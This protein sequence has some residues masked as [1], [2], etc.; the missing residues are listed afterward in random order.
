MKRRLS[1]LLIFMLLALQ[2]MAYDF[3]AVN[4]D[5]QTIYYNILSSNT[6][7]VAAGPAGAYIGV[8]NIPE[9]VTSG[10]VTYDVVGI[11]VSAFENCVELTTVTMPESIENIGNFAMKGCT[12]LTSVTIPNVTITFGTN[13]LENCTS[14]VTFDVPRYMTAIPVAFFKGC[15]SLQSI[16]TTNSLVSILWSAFEGCTGL[17]SD[18]FDIPTSVQAIS[19]NAFKNCTGLTNI[20]IPE[21]VTFI[22]NNTFDNCSSLVQVT[23]PSTLTEIEAYAFRDCSS[24]ALINFPEALTTIGVYAFKSCTSLMNVNMANTNVNL[25]NDYAFEDCTSLTNVTFSDV[26]THTGSYSFHNC[27]ELRSIAFP[28]SYTNVGAR[29]F[30]GCSMLSEV[31]L[32]ST[33][34]SIGSQA[35]KDCVHLLI[36]RCYAHVPPTIIN[37]NCFEGI[38]TEVMTIVVPCSVVDAYQALTPWNLYNIECD[39]DILIQTDVMPFD[40]GYILGD[41]YFTTDEEVRLVAIPRNH[42]VFVSWKEDD[43]VVSTDS[44]YTFTATHDRFLTAIFRH[45]DHLITAT[46]YPEGYGH[47]TGAGIYEYSSVARLMAYPH[48][49]YQFYYWTEN[50]SIVS[51]NT[52]YRFTV[53]YDRDLVAH[54]AP[55]TYNIT[56]TPSDPLAGT[57]SGD[58]TYTYNDT[59]TVEATVNDHY[60]WIG[61]KEFGSVVSTDTTYIFQADRNRDLIASYIPDVHVITASVNIP[62]AATIEG[63]G[64]HYYNTTATLIATGTQHY[65]FRTWTENNVVVSTDSLYNFQVTRDRELVANFTLNHYVVNISTNIPD[66]AIYSGQGTY[67]CGD[68]VY[69]STQAN[70][71]ATFINWTECDTV[72]STDPNFSFVIEGHRNLVANFEV[73]QD[74]HWTP[75]VTPYPNTMMLTGIIQIDGVEQ[76]SDNL[77][78]GAF[79]DTVVRGSQRAQLINATGRY[80]F[81]MTI[82]GNNDEE[83]T[84]KLYNH[85]LDSVLDLECI[86]NLTFVQDHIIGSTASPY[87]LNFISALYVTAVANPAEGGTIYGYGPYEAGETVNMSCVPAMG[88]SFDNWTENGVIL[89]TNA[90][91]SFVINENR[92]LT[93]NFI[94]GNHWTPNPGQYVNSMQMTC[95]IEINGEEQHSNLLEIGAFCG[96]EVRGSQ[97][98][99]YVAAIDRYVAFLLVYGTS[100]DNITFRLYNHAT[101]NESNYVSEENVTLVPNGMIGSVANPYVINFLPA[102]TI[103]TLMNPV[104]AGEITGGGIYP[105]GTEVTLTATGLGS[106]V[107]VNW[108]NNGTLLSESQ[109]YTFDA[110]ES[111]VI[112]ANFQYGQRTP[113]STNWNWYSTFIEMN[114]VDGLS[115]IKNNLMDKAT[116]IKSKTAYI[117]YSNNVWQGSLTNVV[118]EQMYQINMTEPFILGISG[119]VVNPEDHPITL[120]PGIVPNSTDREWNWIGYPMIDTLDVND[121]LAGYDAVNGDMIR[122]QSYYAEYTD[123]IGWLGSLNTLVPGQGYQFYNNSEIEKTLVFQ[124]AKNRTLKENRGTRDNF[125]QP[126]EHKFADVM[127]ITSVIVIQDNEQGDANLEIGAF[128]GEEC[129]GSARPIYVEQLDKYVTYLTIHGEQGD[130]I[131]FKLY[132]SEEDEII[133]DYSEITVTF[134]DNEVLGSTDETFEI[135][136][137][138]ILNANENNIIVGLYPNPTETGA[139]T[140]L[141]TNADNS[142]VAVFNAV[143][144]KIFE[145]TFNSEQILDCFKT[146]GVYVIKVTTPEGET[147]RKIVVK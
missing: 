146:S 42:Y 110:T 53:P 8:I 35:F 51:S 93:A 96:D 23:L 133:S 38:S 108:T 77:E 39:P 28:R 147:Y 5:G 64:E 122:T 116:T 24:L 114:G 125:W 103:T 129:R 104:G 43:N 117:E 26:L 76:Y 44:I 87:A 97:R 18:N 137:N 36:L 78:V 62:E 6:V 32:P 15:T 58:G 121:A 128:C 82:Y 61:W 112:T 142:K 92:F 2:A 21:G 47:V 73:E 46:A 131:T 12:S 144:L 48:A 113:L 40:C 69:I 100:G 34:A 41:G 67:L 29:T 71:H 16:T 55:M 83:I 54:F 85:E 66:V 9:N 86:T 143:G 101:G 109:V 10:S 50:D 119:D 88:Y 37:A 107:F 123:G 105:Y 145:T 59:V 22:D 94:A 99:E 115:M 3:Q 31:I 111:L 141:I 89:S 134:D 1:T 91:F 52:M 65:T 57:T 13:I 139:S 80:L 7:E 20:N 60:N 30:V 95:V 84:F 130:E 75:Y 63:A 74:H 90:S 98:A 17:T 56:T 136:Y 70:L 49:H 4:N 14:L 19:Y 135:E 138:E 68:S 126:D 11:G 132:D 118:N 140:K 106:Y 33:T 25:I 27:V 124:N 72:V 81:Y 127:C 102:I 79:C 120:V 45:R